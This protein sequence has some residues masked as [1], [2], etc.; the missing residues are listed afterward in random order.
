LSCLL[1]GNLNETPLSDPGWKRKALN[2]SAL[3]SAH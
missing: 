1:Y 2:Q 3:D